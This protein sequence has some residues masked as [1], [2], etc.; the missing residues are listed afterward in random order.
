MAMM[1]RYGDNG[2]PCLSPLAWFILLPATPFRRAAEWDVLNR[3]EIQSLHL[4]LKPLCSRNSKIY[5]H[6][7]VSKA[8]E[9]SNLNRS[10]G[11]FVL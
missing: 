5:S 7:M 10:A 2:S 9:M 4:G 8:F 3:I 11:V 1:K 6:E